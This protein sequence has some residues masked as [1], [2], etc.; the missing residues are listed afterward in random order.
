[1]SHKTGP[2]MVHTGGLKQKPF[3]NAVPFDHTCNFLA[4]SHSTIN[5]RRCIFL[6][7]QRHQSRSLATSYIQV[8]I[9]VMFTF[10]KSMIQI[11]HKII[12]M[13]MMLYPCHGSYSKSCRLWAVVVQVHS[14][15]FLPEHLSF[16]LLHSDTLVGSRLSSM[17]HS[18]QI[19]RNCWVMHV[20]ICMHM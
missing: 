7:C 17:S 1:M 20:C 8:C 4:I 5:W 11:F 15:V 3:L 19:R 13:Q 6:K 14:D 2:L 18:L 10:I 12:Y 16:V 9:S